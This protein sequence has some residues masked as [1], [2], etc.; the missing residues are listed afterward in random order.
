M[1]TRKVKI[2]GFYMNSKYF[3]DEANQTIGQPIVGEEFE[4]RLINR[5]KVTS[6]LTEEGKE[7]KL[8]FIEWFKNEF[9]VDI[10]L[11]WSKKC[12]CSMCPCSPGFEIR[13]EVPSK[14]HRFYSRGLRTN[15]RFNYESGKGSFWTVNDGFEDSRRHKPQLRLWKIL[16]E[17]GN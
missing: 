15:P 3:R 5:R 8:Q 1:E 14:K 16:E 7:K 10:K 2:G 4:K 11:N 6:K 13:I 17:L 12:G 9:G